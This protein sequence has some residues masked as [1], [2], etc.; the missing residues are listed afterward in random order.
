MK[1]TM[2][3][4]II[5][6]SIEYLENTQATQHNGHQSQ[7][8][9]PVHEHVPHFWEQKIFDGGGKGLPQQSGLPPRPNK[10]G[11]PG[12]WPQQRLDR[13]QLPP[14]A[15]AGEASKL[16]QGLPRTNHNSPRGRRP[17][18]PSNST[19]SSLPSD[20]PLHRVTWNAEP[21]VV[22]TRPP[23]PPVRIP[24]PSVRRAS[25]RAPS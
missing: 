20:S 19:A 23:S 22:P 3:E 1:N 16:N 17:A 13:G 14:W 6:P 2:N 11:V 12:Q 8:A 4:T 21:L 10:G 24:V 5:N 7:A 9:S 15:Q 18:S 25:A